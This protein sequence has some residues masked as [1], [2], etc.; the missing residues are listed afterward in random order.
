[1]DRRVRAFAPDPGATT[2]FRGEGLK[3]LRGAPI[4]GAPAAPRAPSWPSSPEGVAI[5]T[6]EGTYRLDEVAAAGRR[7][8]SA[9]EWARGA[10]FR[11]GER[12]G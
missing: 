11:P 10:R 2:T 9:V 12:L 8:M 1:M 3:V 4:G 7:R 5:A 6:A